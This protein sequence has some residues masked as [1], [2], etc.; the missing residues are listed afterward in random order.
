MSWVLPLGPL[1]AAVTVVVLLA[2]FG[3]EA[4]F[5]LR[6]RRRAG[7]TAT[8][9]RRDRRSFEVL[10]LAIFA[11]VFST[12]GFVINRVGDFP[13][14]TFWLGVAVFVVGIGFRAWAIRSLGRFFTLHVEVRADQ[15]I[16][17]EG[18]YR[19]I[20]HPAYTGALL[21]L[22]GYP[23]LLSSAWGLVVVAGIAA[24]AFGYRI[25]VEER[26]LLARFGEAYR[27]YERR[28]WRL[29]PYLV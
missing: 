15:R 13:F 9:G 28:T 11:S 14:S 23:I 5:N 21:S 26:A 20:R 27:S 17:Q 16:V 18:P 8:V 6:S 10:I 22:L 29:I 24:V 4:Y 2:W 7:A 1:E 19:W 25:R 12:D 3:S